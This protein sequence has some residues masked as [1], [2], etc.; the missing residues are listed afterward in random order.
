MELEVLGRIVQ[1]WWLL[2]AAALLVGGF[3]G[4]AFGSSRTPVYQA[5]ADLLV[6]PLSADSSVLRAAG[7]T[8]QTYAELVTASSTEAAVEAALPNRRASTA[9]VTATASEVTRI[10][11]IRVRAD[12][13]QLVAD[14]AN[15]IAAELER[16]AAQEVAE[17]VQAGV[18]NDAAD[19][20]IARVGEVRVLESAT[21]PTD[22][23]SPNKQL[24]AALGGLALM[25]AVAVAVIVYEYTRQSVRVVAD[26][27]RIVPG[28]V[29]ARIERSG[30]RSS[31]STDRIAVLRADP[32]PAATGLR[33]LSVDLAS[34]LPSGDHNRA[35]AL[36]GLARGDRSGDVAI[37]VAAAL[38]STGRRVALI[39]ANE[40]NPEVT[41]RLAPGCGR[42]VE[43]LVIDVNP[44]A[45]IEL[46]G[47]FDRIDPGVLDVYRATMERLPERVDLET[48]LSEL[49]AVYDDVILSTAPA[50]GS[51]AA[52]RWAAA[53]GGAVLVVTADVA[54]AGT[55][56]N[57]A[58]TLS[59]GAR[60]FVGAV[61]DERPSTLARPS[62]LRR[63]FGG[64][65]RRPKRA[66]DSARAHAPAASREEDEPEPVEPSP[67]RQEAGARR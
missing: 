23:I 53:A 29:F 63:A 36:S 27:E 7:Q 34:Q 19:P 12:S 44:T 61:F 14:V 3:V 60:H 37:N 55:V 45:R 66:A 59:R 11:K 1:R 41:Q 18:G 9:Q 58:L 56:E 48:A 33:G 32:G 5:G 25:V 54:S 15:A 47:R 57:C 4:Y 49:G 50:F 38:A 42:P 65:E 51:P 40:T 35:V 21:P 62:L 43:P 10:L 26:L 30:D 20:N 6:G 28:G 8:A 22:P 31:E 17:A 16:V 2:V 39:D 52:A 46:E 67:T 64:G 24:T 13:P